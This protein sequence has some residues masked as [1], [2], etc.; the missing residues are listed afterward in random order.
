MLKTKW[1]NEKLT[2][3]NF[4]KENASSI[5]LI[6]F[7]L[8]S[9]VFFG[10]VTYKII[11]VS[12]GPYHEYDDHI[13]FAVK[14]AQEDRVV[15]PHFLFQLLTIIHHYLLGFLKIPT[16]QITG[17]NKT[18]TYDWGFSAL[19]VMLEIYVGI[20][21]LLFYHLKSRFQNNIKSFENLA[22]FIAFGV[23]ICSPIFLLAPVDGLFY[24]GYI[25]P[26]TIYIIPTQVLLKLPSLGLFLLSPIYFTK[27]KYNEKIV[28]IF[29][30]VIL[31]GLS[32]PNW[33]LI[34]IP[35]L[36]II[37]IIKFIKKNYL[38]WLALSITLTSS[39]AVLGWQ[40]YFKF[41]DKTA[42]VYKSEIIITSPFEV[43]G[44]HSDFILMKIIL[45]VLFPLYIAIFFWNKVKDD[46]LFSYGWLLFLI[47]LIYLGFFGESEPFKASANFVWCAQIA[48]FMLFVSAASVFFSKCITEYEKDKKKIIIGCVLF[49]THIIC[50][51]IYYAR[52]FESFFT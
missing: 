47:G 20:E 34:M 33:L 50:G 26:A 15:L 21:L 12:N 14:M 29:F 31:S 39:S 38:N 42:P 36:G 7:I 46:F 17:I 22:Y 25:T 19:I 10:A 18:I 5:K 27:N 28:I 35:A 44:N 6:I 13:L 2:F 30:L 49:F 51:L 45:S 40:Y 1:H 52:A 11:L 4:L 23:S 24:L 16:Y 8:F 41:F 32:K 9:A 3:S 37:S 43:W 48:C